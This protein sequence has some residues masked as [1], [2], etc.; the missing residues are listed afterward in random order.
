MLHDIATG[1]KKEDTKIRALS[2][3]FTIEMHIFTIWKQLPELD[4]VDRVKQDKQKQQQSQ[5]DDDRNLPI[6]DIEDIKGV[7]EIP[8]EDKKLW[9]NWLQ[10][11]G[12]KRYW[13]GEELLAHHKRKGPIKTNCAIP[14]IE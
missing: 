12:C 8:E 6:F 3:I 2:T 14:N 9:H 7:E 11:D 5:E 1:T 13:K 10:C 4:I